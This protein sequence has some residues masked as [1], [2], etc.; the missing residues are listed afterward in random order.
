MRFRCCNFSGPSWAAYRACTASFHGRSECLRKLESLCKS[1]KHRVVKTLRLTLGALRPL[2]IKNPRLKIVH[3]VRDPRAIVH[4]RKYSRFYGVGETEPGD[5]TVELNLCDKMQQDIV[6]G[7][8]LMKTFP[9]RVVV[10]YYEDLIDNLH[11][12]VQQLYSFLNMEYDKNTVDSLAKV[13][14]NLAPPE[15]GINFFNDRLRD[16]SKWW[17]RYMEWTNVLK[18]NDAC[19]VVLDKLGYSVFENEKELRD[20]SFTAYSIPDVFKIP[21]VS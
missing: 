17:R 15:F 11:Q 12:R 21:G 7:E 4:S 8:L 1:Q 19:K 18:V 20:I 14:T 10:L 2:L 6:D 5:R 13:I 9:D 3:L 16:N